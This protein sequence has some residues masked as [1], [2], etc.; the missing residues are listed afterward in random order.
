MGEHSAMPLKKIS[1][2]I[3]IDA[4]QLFAA[5]AQMGAEVE[6]GFNGE[7]PRGKRHNRKQL[8][9][10]EPLMITDQSKP[11]VKTTELAIAFLK[12]QSAP[13]RAKEIIIGI[14]QFDPSKN[15]AAVYFALRTLKDSK[16]VVAKDGLYTLARGAK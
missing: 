14:Q 6:V 15:D 2:N 5:L 12:T 1:F 9:G 8:N 3:T 4:P 7:P 11:K 16:Q 13:V 10:P